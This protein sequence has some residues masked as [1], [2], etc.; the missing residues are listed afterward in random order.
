MLDK[1]LY[2]HIARL[3]LWRQRLLVVTDGAMTVGATTTRA[4]TAGVVIAGTAT[5]G[6]AVKLKCCECGS[7]ES[8]LRLRRQ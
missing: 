8:E 6:I 4:P 5:A 2:G 7:N 1:Y 3:R